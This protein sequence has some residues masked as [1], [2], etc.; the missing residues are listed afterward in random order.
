MREKRG[1]RSGRGEGRGEWSSIAISEAR[2]VDKGASLWLS[3]FA[4]E[5]GN[6]V[7]N[8]SVPSVK[9]DDGGRRIAESHR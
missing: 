2:F 7:T 1:W 5:P 4:K 9:A 3:L 6:E 8:K